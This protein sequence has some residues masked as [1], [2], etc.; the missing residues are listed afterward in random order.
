LFGCDRDG[1]AIAAAQERLKEFVGRFELRQMS[2]SELPEWLEPG[3]CDGVLLDLGVSSPQVE[4]PARGFS[5]QKDG[6]LDMRMDRRQALTA[7]HLVNEASSEELA[8]IFWE[9]GGEPAARRLARGIGGTRECD[10]LRRRS[11]LAELAG[12]LSPRYGKRRIR[13][14]VCFKLC[15]WR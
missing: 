5:F 10:G 1:E 12:R 2:F 14:R 9:L 15:G 13:R 11:Q 3:S 8:N 4:Q 7:A 6:P